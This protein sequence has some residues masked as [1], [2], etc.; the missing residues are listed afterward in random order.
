MTKHSIRIPQVAGTSKV[1]GNVVLQFLAGSRALGV[2]SDM[3]LREARLNVV[4]ET[5]TV[6]PE[7]KIKGPKG[8]SLASLLQCASWVAVL[9]CN[10][11]YS[12]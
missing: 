12:A 8:G 5:H 7:M 9:H 10:L 11:P 3:L 2:L 1:R 4:C 6:L